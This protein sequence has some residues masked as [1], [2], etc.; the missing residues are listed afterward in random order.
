[1][2][3]LMLQLA[4][5]ILQ[6]CLVFLL[7][8]RRLLGYFRFFFFYTAYAVATELVRFA[9][10]KKGGWTWTYYYFYWT[11]NGLYAI[12]ACFAI[13]EV[14]HSVFR[15]FDG[16]RGFRYLFP[17]V[18]L[19]MITVS[20]VRALTRHQSERIP[21]LAVI[22]AIQIAVGFLQVGLFFLFI[23][24]VRLFRV[25]SR[26]YAFG[27]A[28]GFGI[29]AAGN[30]SFYLLRSEFGTKLNHIVLNALPIVYIIAVMVWLLTFLKPQPSHPWQDG[31]S[32]LDPE[33]LITELRQYTRVAK[34]V[35][36]R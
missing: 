16:I 18:A 1:M 3:A 2:S 31:G 34:G 32:A 26:R 11:T 21:Y 15:N 24:L 22:I 13:Y 35:L 5:P 7:V 20:I 23:L 30:L 14:F 19:F 12:L 28:L 25:Q 29:S 8:R 6:A 17:S 9:T 27:I 33:E 4:V 10:L 36:R